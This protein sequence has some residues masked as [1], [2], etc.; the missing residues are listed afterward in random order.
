MNRYAVIT[1]RYLYLTVQDVEYR[2]YVEESGTGVPVVLQ[3]TA[4]CDN[5]QWRHLL[6]APEII[7]QFR[8]IAPDLPFH[9]KSVPPT[10]VE[11]WNQDYTLT[12]EFLIA[13]HLELADALQ[14]DRPIFVGCSMGGHLGADLALSHPDRY[15]AVVCVE[16]AL[17]SHGMERVLPYL[18]HPEIGNDTKAGLMYTFCSPTSPEE[19]KRETAWVYSQGAPSVFK[20]DLEYYLIEHDLTETARTIDTSKIGVWIL[21]GEY[22]WTA[23]PTAGA[24]LAGEIEGSHF[25]TMQGVGH[26]P[27]SENP[28]VF[29][30]V[31]V[32]IL[33][34][35]A[36]PEDVSLAA[37][38]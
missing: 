7:G 23:P 37:Q 32:P 6:E 35:A 14:L 4:G 3:H 36:A 11:W 29:K 1:G 26:F 38:H 33:H 15:R 34:E 9:G 16:A 20:G 30:R 28:E 25:V 10:S 12:E 22:D 27:M 21:S 5:R 24:L 17:H 31:L 2:V 18:Y 13:F 19:L 8:L